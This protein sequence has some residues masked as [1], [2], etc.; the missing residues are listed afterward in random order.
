MGEV[1]GEFKN[2][3]FCPFWLKE[4]SHFSQ[5]LVTI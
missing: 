5:N 2:A 3:A 4:T 1:I